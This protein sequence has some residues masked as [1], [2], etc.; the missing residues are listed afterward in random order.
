MSNLFFL[1]HR[2][3]GCNIR[4]GAYLRECC[5]HPGS[6]PADSTPPCSERFCRLGVV[7]EKHLLIHGAL[8][9]IVP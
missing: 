4:C 8:V 9:W 6:E 1:F 3:Q 2:G 5:L 7:A